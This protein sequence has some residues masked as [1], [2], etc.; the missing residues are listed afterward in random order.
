MRSKLHIYGYGSNNADDT[1]DNNYADGS[2]TIPLDYSAADGGDTNLYMVRNNQ[3]IG[4]VGTDTT[5]L[6]TDGLPTNNFPA[7]GDTG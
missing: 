5:N 3:F 7:D 4:Y 2:G 6:T 1:V